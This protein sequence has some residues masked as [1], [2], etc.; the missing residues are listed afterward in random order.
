MI[1]RSAGVVGAVAIGVA[2]LRRLLGGWFSLRPSERSLVKQRRYEEAGDLCVRRGDHAAALRHFQRGG[3]WVK[4]GHSARRLGKSELAAS[5]FEQG[6]AQ[7]LARA[8]R[9]AAGGGRGRTAPDREAPARRR[10]AA[11]APRVSPARPRPNPPPPD[12]GLGIEQS[13]L[14]GGEAASEADLTLE[15]PLASVEALASFAGS[16]PEGEGS[17]AVASDPAGAEPPEA[18]LAEDRRGRGAPE[19]ELMGEFL[20]PASA[21]TSPTPTAVQAPPRR[22]AN[23]TSDAPEVTFS[24][25]VTDRYTIRERLGEGGMAEVYRAVDRSLG[26]TIAIKFLSPALMGNEIA[27]MYFRRE[28]RAAAAL[29]HPAIVTIYDLGV[30][31]GRPYITM[32]YIDGVDLE[33]RLAAE[34]ALSFRFGVTVAYQVSRALEYAHTRQVVHRDVKPANIMLVRDGG[35][36]ILDFGLAKALQTD[37]KGK[38]IVA[39]TP[40]YMSPEQLAGGEIDGRTDIFAFGVTLYESL[41]GRL[42]FQ[43]ALRSS[44]VTLLSYYLGTEAEKLDRIVMRCLALDPD[45]RYATTAE[46]SNELDRVRSAFDR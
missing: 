25:V 27:M 43:G 35:I 28:A 30:L 32:E 34:G 20:E 10:S 18:A 14:S 4:A 42:P 16:E 5:L 41:T 6:G 44:E 17:P 21:G 24:R 39:G 46:L 26:R 36:R 2:L 1:V 38:S 22:R 23:K 40:E 3:L 12:L 37:R 8:A 29:N 13:P 31:D 19:D 33:T 7:K 9:E 15:S 45:D 11:R